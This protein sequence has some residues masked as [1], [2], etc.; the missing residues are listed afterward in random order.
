MKD[1]K[2]KANYC[3]PNFLA[4]AMSKVDMRTQLEASLM[5]MTLILIGM[6]ISIF[7]FIFYVSFVLWY[8]IVLIIN[9]L[10]GLI[11]ISSFIITTFQQ[12]QS[13]LSA[14]GFQEELKKNGQ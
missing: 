10:A 5:S 6:V 3:F 12:Y 8:K 9:L 4:Q 14:I 2:K 13:Y 11:F 1:E 7:Y